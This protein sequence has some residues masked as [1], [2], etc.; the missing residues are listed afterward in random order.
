MQL[1]VEHDF[2]LRSDNGVLKATN[3]LVTSIVGYTNQIIDGTGSLQVLTTSIVPEGSNLYFTTARAQAAISGSAPISVSSGVVSIS[4]ANSTTNGYLS[5]TDWSTFNAKQAALNGTGFVKISG[6][7]ISYDNSSYYLASNPNSY[8]Q[9]TALSASAPLSY[10]NT[11]GAF[12]I[13]Q[14]GASSNGYLSSTDWNTFNAKQNA[15][16]YTPVPNTRQLTINGTTYDLSA[17]RTWT[18]TVPVTSVFGRTGAVT[19][20]SGDYTTTQVTEGTN[21]YF[22]N[23]RAI[24]ATLTGYTSGSGTITSSDSIL[25]AIQKL[26]GNVGL[27]TGAIIYQGTW[28]ASTNTPTLTS[29]V[30]NKG[31]MYKVAVAGST[32][33][34]G[35][36][37]WNVGDQLVFNGTVWDKID[38]IPNEVLSVFG[39]VGAVT[40][41]SGD[42]TTTLVTEG[43]NLYYTQ[44]RFDSAFSAKTTTNLTEGTNLYFTN[45]R[46]QNAITLT[47]TDSSGAATYSGG[48]LNIPNYGS[49][50]SGYVPYTGATG[51][52][53]LGSYNLSLN[54]LQFASIS[55]P[56]YSEGLVWYDSSQKSLAFYN[57]SSSSIVYIGEDVQMKVVN[58]T[59]ATIPNGSAVYVIGTSSGQSY[60]NIALAQANSL[61]TSAVIGLTNGAIPN[62][63]IGYVTSHGVITG[64]NTSML[65]V[66]QV[67]YLSPYSAG[68]L[69]NTVPPTGYAVQVGTV[70][71]A[72]S[73]NGSIYVKQTTPLA[74]SASTITGIISIANGGTGA[75]TAAGALTN[76]GG[77]GL[78]SL[79]ASSPLSYNN[80][81]GA[82]SITQATN[83][84][85]GYLSSTDWTTFNNK[86]AALGG[87][88]LV[89]STAGSITY[90]TD[91][92]S[93]WNS[94][95]AIA[96]SLNGVSPINFNSITGAISISQANT[97]TNGYLSSTDWN[98]FNGKQ[99]AL[100]GTGFVKIIGTTISYDN[101]TYATDASVV[102]LAGTETI[103]GYKSFS[104]LIYA[105]G[106]I[107]LPSVG[108]SSPTYLQNL[109]VVGLSSFG[110]NNLGFNSNNNF[111]LSADNKGY[112]EFA[113]NNAGSGR[114]YTFPSTSGTVALTSNITSAISGNTNY[115][116]K[117]TGSNA[118]G[119]SLIYDTGSAVLIGTTTAGSGKFTVYSSTSDNHIQ[120]IGA[121]P[122]LRLADTISTPTYTMVIGLATASN[123]FIAGSIAGDMVLSNNTTSVAGNF[124]FGAGATERMRINGSTGYVSIGNTNNTYNLDVT[125]TG[126]F[127]GALRTSNAIIDGANNGNIAVLNWTRTDY[128]WSVNNE[129]NLRFYVQSGNTLS[130]STKVLEIATSGA[131]TFSSSVTATNFAAG[132]ASATYPFNSISAAGTQALLNS[133]RTGGGGIILQNNGSDS[134]YLGT[135]NWAGVSGFGTA[136]TD[137]ALAAAANSSAIVF[138]T[139]TSVTERMRITSGGNVGIGTSSPS[140]RLVVNGSGDQH[141]QQ[142][143]ST[144][145]NLYTIYANTNKTYYAG[146]SNDIG[147]SSYII[148]DG[149]AGA[150]RMTITS[151]GNVLIGTTTDNG[152]KL[153]VSGTIN[154]TGT[155][156]ANGNLATLSSVFWPITSGGNFQLYPTGTTLYL[157]NS[158]VGN[159]GGFNGSTGVYTP[160]SDIN[161]KKDFEDS[162]IGLAAI[163]NLKPTL[164]R[165][166]GE[167]NTE[168]HL[169]FIAQEVK[170]Y[171]PQAYVEQDEFIGLNFNSITAALVKAIQEMSA[172]IEELRKIISE[173]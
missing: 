82:F 21:L 29:G 147:P 152:Q 17:D 156:T 3:G 127:T 107:I 138:A 74:V 25:S 118:I 149:T 8:I 124:L 72:N 134:V 145:S 28:N 140:N 76:L 112:A 158:N 154:S 161:K 104:S 151:G 39:R 1:N 113:Y 52:V 92:S 4:Q 133:T 87:T 137:I 13:S 108:T 69:M 166:K 27:L 116:S 20:Q 49:A 67:L 143:S 23:A 130:P 148:Y 164:Y 60:P 144:A 155:I 103:T 171:I 84:T 79:S 117:F 12:T 91:N 41:Q 66:G 78:T 153:Q 16:G 102:H 136:T 165:M 45:T 56:S 57:D 126:R 167:E 170:D 53:N 105:N 7:T 95:S 42:Y 55:A 40:A 94:G 163:L 38:G 121:A 31:Y 18:I 101:T 77:I 168:K 59:G 62:G 68:Q 131:A 70:T 24:G 173:K 85:N 160:L 119:N 58:N 142:V 100:N 5:S 43:T 88:G 9:L 14:S 44:S 114:T 2:T 35:V 50:L 159:I 33:I 96:N 120:A 73:S 22:T 109:N 15:L 61:S 46:A 11:T 54:S 83:A 6:T 125:G 150:A 139:G 132:S 19:A 30:G 51:N 97:S 106:N 93:S 80:T 99:A 98:T 48:T 36:T 10:N 146:L 141:I 32:N 157:Y 90:I 34:D 162:T 63:A 135:A 123:N 110:A 129:T 122:S 64:V 71:Y 169:G 115:V 172:Q 111:Y 86:Q 65:T 37:Q 81:T 128:S 75:S 47:T 89:K 26:N